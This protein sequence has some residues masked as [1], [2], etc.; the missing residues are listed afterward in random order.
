MPRRR[1][2]LL[3]AGLI[4]AGSILWLARDY[5][6]PERS[7]EETKA[8]SED[9]ILEGRFAECAKVR[10]QYCHRH[11]DDAAGH[12]ALGSI[13]IYRHRYDAAERELARALELAPSLPQAYLWRGTLLEVRS[14]YAGADR[15]YAR[16]RELADEQLAEDPDDEEAAYVRVTALAARS[17]SDAALEA[18]EAALER[19]PDDLWM[20]LT[21]AGILRDDGRLD[22]AIDECNRVLETRPDAA[23]A[24]YDRGLSL[25]DRGETRAA[26]ESFSEALEINP[27]YEDVLLSRA[28]ASMTLGDIPAAEIDAEKALKANRKSPRA[29]FVMGTIYIESLRDE[30]LPQAAQHSVLNAW[31]HYYRQSGRARKHL[32]RAI[33]LNPNVAP[34]HSSLAELL[35]AAGREAEAEEHARTAVDLYTKQIEAR[36]PTAKDYIWRATAWASVEDYAEARADVER[37][38][39]AANTPSEHEVAEE[40]L[41]YL[42]QVD[43]RGAVGTKDSEA[44]PDWSQPEDAEVGDP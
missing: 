28:W 13:L 42:D 40:Y 7:L 6:G 41:D 37:A 32:K 5:F 18:A 36:E 23:A 26:I 4:V 44:P 19:R 20:R 2:L 14:D 15:D 16:A 38:M 31:I 24:L 9:L 22:E 12:S 35:F 1:A 3:I 43:P 30:N 33:E 17:E 39:E 21:L 29:W 11:P 25:I 34:A 27:R 10:A 8:L